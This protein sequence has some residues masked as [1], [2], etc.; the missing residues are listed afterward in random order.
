MFEGCLEKKNR[1]MKLVRPPPIYET[2]SQKKN[3]IDDF[4]TKHFNIIY[5]NLDNVYDYLI[6]V[7]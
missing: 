2:T 3:Y 1:G 4:P 7:I 6:F 5:D